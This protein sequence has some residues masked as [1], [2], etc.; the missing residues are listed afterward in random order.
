MAENKIGKYLLYASGEIILIVI[1]IL[2]AFAIN[3]W[4]EH[5]KT[6]IQDIELLNSL[7]V[8]LSVDIAALA[9][10]KSH[11]E[12]IND[13]IKQTITLFNRGIGTLSEAEHQ[14]IHLALSQ[15]QMFSPIDKNINR[16]DLLI[17][18]GTIDRIDKELNSKF[19]QYLHETQAINA[20]IT[21]LGETL[22]QLEILRIHPHVDYNYID[23]A[24][25]K[26]DFDFKEIY[27]RRE[28]RNTLQR[29][30]GYHKA[31][32][33]IMTTKIKEAEIIISLIDDKLE[34]SYYNASKG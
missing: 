2:V 6:R 17:A 29:S 28:V 16:N 32:I 18:R 8:E 24:A 19:V 30:F 34:K 33:D 1:G 27:N 3:N 20:A 14:A 11:Y 5:R 13:N 4:N 10:R 15:F 21:K 22:Q 23:P 9:D 12:N 31:Y 25:N 7:K 26:V